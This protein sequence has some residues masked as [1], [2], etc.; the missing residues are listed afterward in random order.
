MKA[1][2]ATCFILSVLG[3]IVAYLPPVGAGE[4]LLHWSYGGEA[5]PTQWGRLGHDFALCEV[6]RD[7]SPIDIDDAVIGSP[8]TIE[9]NYASVP[10]VVVNNR[11]TI[12]VNYA[13]G[14]TVKIDGDEYELLQFHFHT[15]SEHTAEGFASAMELH[16][17]H[18]NEA[19]ELAVVGIML[20]LGEAHPLI[21]TLWE[22]IPEVGTTQTTN[23]TINAADLL[24]DSIAYFSYSGSLTTPPCSEGVRW[25]VMREPVQVS[26]AQIAAFEA[27]YPVNARPIQSTNGRIIELHEDE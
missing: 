25:N 13:E 11:H 26:E 15:P 6:G 21:D 14:S 9:F 23:L 17:V 24:P 16:L 7:Q 12:Q 2:K 1:L 10:L 5:N 22:N 4:E 8:S 3:G 19:G 18:R 27:L 20:E